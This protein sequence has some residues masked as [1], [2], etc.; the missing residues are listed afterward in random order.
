MMP[1]NHINQSKSILLGMSIKARFKMPDSIEGCR[2][3]KNS[4]E[5]D[6]LCEFVFNE[7]NKIY[8]ANSE[9][10]GMCLCFLVCLL[11]SFGFQV[12]RNMI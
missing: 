7:R 6:A 10:N 12:S 2:S 8:L 5:K 3:M 9:L 4:H 1:S 11:A